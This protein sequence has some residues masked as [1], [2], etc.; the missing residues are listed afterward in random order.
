MAKVGRIVILCCLSCITIACTLTAHFCL[1]HLLLQ[2]HPHL[3]FN[4][5]VESIFYFNNYEAHSG[6][7]FTAFMS[8]FPFCRCCSALVLFCRYLPLHAIGSVHC[9]LHFCDLLM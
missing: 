2:R 5:F 4:H 8:V 9:Y 6:Q 1:M 3:F 7:L